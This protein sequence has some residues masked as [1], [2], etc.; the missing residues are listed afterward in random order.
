MEIRTLFQTLI[1]GWWII[2]LSALAALTV[3]LFLSYTATPQYRARVLLIINPNA[4]IAN[5]RDVVDSLDTLDR[6]SILSTYAEVLVSN[7]IYEETLKSLELNPVDLEDYSHTAVVLPE[8]FVLELTVDG[9]NPVVSAQ[10]ANAIGRQSITYTRR[11]NQVYD[12]NFLD[13]AAAPVEPFSP[14]PLR[15]AALALALGLVLGVI[16]TI[17]RDQIQVPIDAIR[18][19]TMIDPA[20]SAYN[21]RYFQRGLEELQ[22]RNEYGNVGLGL[23]QLDGLSGLIETLSPRMTQTL[24]HTVNSRLR[25]QLRGNDRVG[26]WDELQFSVLLPSTPL[27]AAERTLDRICQALS[28]PVH[29]D[30]VD[31]PINLEPYVSVVVGEHEESAQSMIARAEK[32]L[33]KARQKHFAG[34]DSSRSK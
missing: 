6:R 3:A 4:S 30:Q 21:R 27:T 23:I 32:A 12:L 24:F 29:L 19:Q 28:E 1:R 31:G 20:S 33:E 7:S 9:P 26:R 15:D 11:L 10:L 18:Y 22:A 2:L 17:V 14:Q 13:T 8:S 34:S 5:S 25:E 16:L